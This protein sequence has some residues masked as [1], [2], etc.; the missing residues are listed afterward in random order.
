MYH[1]NKKINIIS[2]KDTVAKKVLKKIKFMYKN[3]PSYLQEP[4][5]NGR[6]GEF[7]SVSTIEF[8]NG[9]VIESIPT[10]DQAGRSES[11]S[12]LVIDEAAIVRWASTI[13]AS[14]FPT[15][16]TGGAAIVNSCITGDTQII[17]KDGPFRVDSICP[18]L[19]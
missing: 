8:A 5:I 19:W 1:P 16:S 12:L 7:G 9:S 3:L 13:W 18:K 4:I 14:A 6:A 10:S 17:G 11:L 15:L 2:I